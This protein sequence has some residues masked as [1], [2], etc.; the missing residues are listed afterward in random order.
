MIIYFVGNRTI[1]DPW[2]FRVLTGLEV[3]SNSDCCAFVFKLGDILP[4]KDVGLKISVVTSIIKFLIAVRDDNYIFILSLYFCP[5]KVFL[6]SIFV[7]SLQLYIMLISL[8][9][10]LS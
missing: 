5:V 10:F 2:E 3:R 8:F 4:K 9:T 6:F 1:L 7:G